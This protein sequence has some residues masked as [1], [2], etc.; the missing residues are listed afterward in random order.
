MGSW[1]E[2]VTAERA[3]TSSTHRDDKSASILSVPVSFHVYNPSPSF[4]KRSPG[5]PDSLLAVC[6]YTDPMP[7]HQA[8]AALARRHRSLG[9][10]APDDN[11]FKA[12]EC[13]GGGECG[14]NRDGDYSLE[15]EDKAIRAGSGGHSVLGDESIITVGD[16][17]ESSVGTVIDGG[18]DGGVDGGG[19]DA[20]EGG[21]T[22][23][24]GGCGGKQT[25][26]SG[27]EAVSIKNDAPRGVKVAV[28]SPDGGV[29]LFDVG[30]H[31]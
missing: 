4:R 27:A 31:S 9:R 16:F 7:T 25:S 8:L 21:R 6:R 2:H 28:V 15:P 22:G 19:A 20:V 24:V 13:A 23:D 30:L 10:R 1:D 3:G 17:Q 11:R 12:G 18:V 14:D 29:H 5:P 26:H